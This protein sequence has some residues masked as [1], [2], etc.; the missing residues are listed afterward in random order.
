MAPTPGTPG[1]DPFAWLRTS[2]GQGFTL[3]QGGSHD[4]RDIQTPSHTPLTSL[5]P[6]VV[7]PHTGWYPWGGEVD[8]RT[9][10]GV[11]ETFAHL[12]AIAVHPGDV[13]NIGQVIGLSGG[14]N[15][16]AQYSNGP[17]THFSL[18]G[19]APW[20]NS[21]A[22]DPTGLLQAFQG[23]GPSGPGGTVAGSAWGSLGNAGSIPFGGVGS[24]IVV[25]V[26]S[27]LDTLSQRLNA[28]AT[29]V[30]TR[31]V[32]IAFG[33]VLL[34]VGVIVLIWP[35]ARATAGTAANVAT[36]ATLAAA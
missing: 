23:S 6:G 5:V 33:L 34:L 27:S 17:H 28:S 35:G 1:Y 22:I 3:P 18:F 15:L 29:D 11:T 24:P 31:G 20:D 7:T 10:G 9:A 25:T 19:G 13:V 4:G 26:Q 16:P 32:L 8:V 14:E 30:L 2:L 36:K 12:D 21:K